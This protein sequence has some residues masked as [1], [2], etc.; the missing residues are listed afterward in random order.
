MSDDDEASLEA[1]IEKISP[2]SRGA[3]VKL[4][5]SWGSD[6]FM[7]YGKEIA[8][9]ML[10]VV[11][12][13]DATDAERV[14]AANQ[15]V[16]FA[17]DQDELV[18]EL[19]DEVS[20][21]TP[22]VVAVGIVTAMGN[23]SASEVGNMLIDQMSSMTPDLKKVAFVQLLKRATSTVALLDAAKNGNVSLGDL[24]LDQKQALTSHPNR[25]I[26]ESA[27]ELLKQ[28]GSL[29]SA[30]RQKVLEEYLVSTTSRGGDVAKGKAIFKEQCS[31]CHVH[32]G[33]GAVVGPDLTGMAVHPKV[34]LLT[35]I[36]DPSRSVEGNFRA[37]SVLT[38]DGVIL[39][40]M[41]ASES[42]TSIELFDT[43]GKKISVLRDDIEQL[44]MSTNSIMPEG[45]E[46]SITTEGMS[47]LLEFLTTARA[48][49]AAGHVQNRDGLQRHESVRGQG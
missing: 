40:G 39:T 23:S 29:P 11:R 6:K 37:Y 27:T 45:F 33:E 47:D 12:D 7:K 24:D 8:N 38:L 13:E 9:S 1:I 2:S 5:T 44:N 30:D 49:P 10:A 19:M 26:R 25:A 20:P 4:A 14:A 3:L 31:K 42:K 15:L 41:L 32:G 34:E 17:G 48:I 21:R 35:H 46:K 28:G 16:E 43:A 18:Q 36:L 22:P